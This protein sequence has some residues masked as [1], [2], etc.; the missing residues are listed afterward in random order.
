MRQ[1]ESRENPVIEVK[2]LPPVLDMLYKSKS[3]M[4]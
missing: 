3:G 4:L 2:D 1:F